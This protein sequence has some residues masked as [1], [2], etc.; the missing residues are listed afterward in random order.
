M[1][2]DDQDRAGAP[3]VEERARPLTATQSS[4]QG[5]HKAGRG[6]QRARP[7]E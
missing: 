6:P 5:A 3:G 7:A 2:S 4:A 1:E